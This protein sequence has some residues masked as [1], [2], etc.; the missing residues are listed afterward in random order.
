[1]RRETLRSAVV[2]ENVGGGPPVVSGAGTGA[3]AVVG[4]PPPPVAPPPHALTT[5]AMDA[6]ATGM[7]RR[8]ALD[9]DDWR[10]CSCA[11]VSPL[12]PVLALM[13][14]AGCS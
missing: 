13:I 2:R 3:G 5:S 14:A 1:M 7:K 8:L 10:S 9:K 11:L 6:A 4:R 12:I